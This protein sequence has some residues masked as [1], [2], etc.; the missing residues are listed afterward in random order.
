MPVNLPS[1]ARGEEDVEDKKNGVYE[2]VN[3]TRL[4]DYFMLYV[5]GTLLH[6]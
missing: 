5:A 6:S 4:C 1:V 3:P 2:T